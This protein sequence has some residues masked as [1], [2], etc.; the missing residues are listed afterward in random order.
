M[1]RDL[2]EKLFDPS[3]IKQRDG[4]FGKRL[5][6]IE[7]HAVIQRLNE[8]LDAQWSFTILEHHI[9]K[10]TDEIMVLGQLKTGEVVKSQFGSSRI[11]RAKETGEPISL[12]DDYKAAATDSLKKCA[13]MLG[14]GLHLYGSDKG[15]PSVPKSNPPR[16][17]PKPPEPQKGNGGNGGN[18]NNRLSSAQF[19]YILRL[20]DEAGRSRQDLDRISLKMFGV[21]TQHLSKSDAH[22]MIQNLLSN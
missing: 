17:S 3:Q 10:E 15:K 1:N 19:K 9:L 13:T 12:A 7:G 6:Y 11:T 5:D 8:A 4:N 14:V 20:G 16:E 18:G 22:A 2:L 21:V